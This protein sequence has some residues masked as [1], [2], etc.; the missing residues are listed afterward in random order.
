MLLIF[1][2]SIL[3]LIV[4]NKYYVCVAMV[5]NWRVISYSKEIKAKTVTK[6]RSSRKSDEADWN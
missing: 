4:K 2:L 1:M 3:N 5:C 6:I